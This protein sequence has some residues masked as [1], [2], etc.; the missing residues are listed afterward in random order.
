MA[1]QRRTLLASIL[2]LSLLAVP[3]GTAG[4]EECTL[5]PASLQSLVADY[6]EHVEQAPGLVRSQFAGERIDV[7]L[8]A[9]G[10]E[11][12]FA[13]VT[14]A[15][16]RITA[17]EEGE[18]ED[19][20]LRVETTESTFC[21]VVGADDHSAAFVDAYES[22]AIEVSGVGTVNAVKVGAVKF[23]VTITRVLSGLF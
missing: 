8:D 2:L 18:A 12:R 16:G 5:D 21:S 19:P 14:A 3:V 10:G 17:F 7:R 22:G 9:S 11:R 1:L 6:N 15:D 20:T 13:V 23:G 4:A